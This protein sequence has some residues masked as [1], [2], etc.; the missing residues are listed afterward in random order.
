MSEQG[1]T[2]RVVEAGPQTTV[3]DAGRPGLAHL[4]VPRSGWLDDRAA[5][6]ANR[7]VGNPPGAAVLECLLGGLRLRVGA[8]ITVA[9]TGAPCR[10][11]AGARPVAFGEPMT[12]AAGT[13]LVLG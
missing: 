2:L 13:E 6:L 4:G 1:R 3:Q 5:R 9:V 12:L 11:G 10:V 7:L 8:A